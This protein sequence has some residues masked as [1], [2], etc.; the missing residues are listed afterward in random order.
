MTPPG[1]CRYVALAVEAKKLLLVLDETTTKSELLAITHHNDDLLAAHDGTVVR[2][3][4][5]TLAPKNPEKQGF[6]DDK[7]KPYDYVSRYFAPWAG[8]KEDPATGSFCKQKTTKNK[9][10]RLFTM[11][12]GTFLVQSEAK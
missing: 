1:K 5:V 11:C 8:I 9:Y 2:G 4:V 6:V 3:I 12:I 7:G 10:L